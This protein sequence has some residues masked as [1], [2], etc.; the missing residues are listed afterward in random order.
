MD[1]LGID[2]L[3]GDAWMAEFRN[4]AMQFRPE[5]RDPEDFRP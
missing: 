2:G 5:P 3:P 4:I 1:T